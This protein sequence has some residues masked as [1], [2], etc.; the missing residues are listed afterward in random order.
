M[1]E[2]NDAKFHIS[3]VLKR[4]YKENL[5][6]NKDNVIQSPIIILGNTNVDLSHDSSF[7]SINFITEQNTSDG[8]NSK[9]GYGCRRCGDMGHNIRTCKA[10]Q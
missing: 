8:K 5:Q 9:R 7:N 10:T 1:M 4:W 6:F 2:T 3:M